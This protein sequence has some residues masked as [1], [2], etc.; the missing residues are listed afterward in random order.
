MLRSGERGGQALT[1]RTLSS[2]ERRG[3]GGSRF[4]GGRELE[5]CDRGP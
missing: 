1:R 4:R 2:S 5:L 3:G